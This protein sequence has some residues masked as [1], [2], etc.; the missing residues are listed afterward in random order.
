MVLKEARFV[1][2]DG[3]R[4]DRPLDAPQFQALEIC[5]AS[6]SRG[7][8]H[9]SSAEKLRSCL[10]G[11]EH[12]IRRQF[13]GRMTGDGQMRATIIAVDF[14]AVVIIMLTHVKSSMMM[15]PG[16]QSPPDPRVKARGGVPPWDEDSLP[17]FAVLLPFHRN[18]VGGVLGGDSERLRDQPRSQMVKADQTHSRHAGAVDKL[19]RNGGGKSFPRTIGSTRKLTRIRRSI[20]PVTTGIFMTPARGT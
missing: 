12:G 3:Q 1:H 4:S 16:K 17:Q 2:F 11:L 10:N 5:R 20:M 15:R 13:I 7:I 14:D 18:P 6:G 19:G 9:R 8:A